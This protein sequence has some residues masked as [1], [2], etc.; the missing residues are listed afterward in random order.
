MKQRIL[1]ILGVVVVAT[2][3]MITSQA[4]RVLIEGD[5]LQ[6]E[7]KTWLY[8]KRMFNKTYEHNSLVD[9]LRRTIFAYNVEKNLDF[10]FL[11]QNPDT[12]FFQQSKIFVD[13]QEDEP[14][15]DCYAFASGCDSWNV[16]KKKHAKEYS[17]KIED[18]LRKGIYIGKC[19]HLVAHRESNRCNQTDEEVHCIDQTADWSLSELRKEF[20]VA[21]SSRE[22]ER[23]ELSE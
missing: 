10:L 23:G 21:K 13:E 1:V 19:N 11:Y 12:P 15:C 18:D 17:N 4:L 5:G 20:N 8:Y 9:E 22:D 3:H 16:F 2:A 14:A 6:R 7:L